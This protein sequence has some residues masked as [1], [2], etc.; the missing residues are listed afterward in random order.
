MVIWNRIKRFLEASATVSIRLFRP[1]TFMLLTVL[2]IGGYYYPEP[3]VVFLTA[4]AKAPDWLT[5]LLTVLVVG[6]ASEKVVREY[7]EMR[8]ESEPD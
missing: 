1:V 8:N 4:A 3:F 2:F 6:V 7:G 5:N